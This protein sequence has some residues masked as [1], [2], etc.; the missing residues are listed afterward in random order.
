MAL[1]KTAVNIHKEVKR[2]A[3]TILDKGARRTYL[4]AMIDAEISYMAGKNRKFS[5]PATSQRPRSER[6]TPKD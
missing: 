2:I 3:A 6:E 4:N 5:D 1:A